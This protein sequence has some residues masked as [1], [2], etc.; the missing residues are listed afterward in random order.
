MEMRANK[1]DDSAASLPGVRY[2]WQDDEKPPSEWDQWIAMI[3]LA[4]G[5]KS[6]NCEKSENHAD[7]L[8]FATQ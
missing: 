6:R 8:Q 5:Q 2:L 1:S 4:V 3:E 7:A